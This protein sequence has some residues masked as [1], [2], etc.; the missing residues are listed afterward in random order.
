MQHFLCSFASNVSWSLLSILWDD[1]F[2]LS[3]IRVI[4]CK[5]SHFLPP[6]NNLHF[7]PFF[8]L[9]PIRVGDVSSL[10]I[11]VQFLQ[12]FLKDQSF[13]LLISPCYWIINR[14][15]FR[16][17]CI[18]H[19]IYIK[20]NFAFTYPKAPTACDSAFFA[21]ISQNHGLYSVLTF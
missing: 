20:K 21:T 15:H 17:C 7:H 3:S 14:S 8:L 18:S 19:Y 4:R 1:N 11:K 13:F 16:S 5:I 6:T 2:D 10:S 9:L 12:L